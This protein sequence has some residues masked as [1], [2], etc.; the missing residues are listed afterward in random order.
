MVRGIKGACVATL[1]AIGL[2]ALP[3]NAG[4]QGKLTVYPPNPEERNFATSAGGF[5]D[6]VERTGLCIPVLTCP[7]VDNFHEP[8]GGVGGATDGFLRTQIGPLLGVAGESRAIWTSSPFVYRG[9]GGDAPDEVSLSITRRSNLGA[10]LQVVGNEAAYSVELLD[11]N[12]GFVSTRLVSGV[13]L[14]PTDG[15]VK[16]PLVDVDPKDLIRGHTYRVR[17]ISRFE[18]GVEALQGGRVDFDNLALAASSE[19]GGGR[20]GP[21]DRAPTS[22]ACFDG[23]RLFIKLKCFG[24][25]DEDGKCH[26]RATALKTKKGVRYTFPIQRVVKAKKGKVIRAR[27]RFRYRKE[28]ERRNAIILKSVLRAD[29]KDKSK[30]IKYKKLKLIDRS[31]DN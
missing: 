18:Y 14:K 23:R 31:P 1:A 2:A 7:T 27:V 4:A 19:D 8:N 11:E 5:T 26:S 12:A 17:I 28:L 24:A 29:R 6:E 10:L 13:S 15:W 16:S 25:Q 22:G 9:A 20:E 21:C 30:D 3:S